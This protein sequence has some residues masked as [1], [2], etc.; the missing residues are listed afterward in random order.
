[1]TEDW[2]PARVNALIAFWDEG[3]TTSEIGRR[4]GVTKNAVIGK[5]HRLGLP[6]RRVSAAEKPKEVAVI[7][8][9]GLRAGM[10]SWPEGDPGTENF[11]FCAAP[12]VPGK[13]YCADHCAKAYV[14]GTKEKTTKAA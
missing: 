13:P 14:K 6:K 7:T 3:L 5:V 2:T 1:M 4:L 11:R 10:C 9:D 12:T 8:L